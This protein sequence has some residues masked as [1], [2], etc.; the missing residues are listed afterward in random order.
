MNKEEITQKIA[1]LK[2][3]F[4]GQPARLK[5]IEG[6]ERAISRQN[7]DEAISELMSSL[8]SGLEDWK[9]NPLPSDYL[10]P[11]VLIPIRHLDSANPK[12]N[13]NKIQILDGIKNGRLD[14]AFFSDEDLE[15]VTILYGEK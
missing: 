11:F 2:S 12:Y 15:S 1:E 6:F 5:F 8:T 4:A 13:E 7:S 3:K 9:A 14:S 10:C